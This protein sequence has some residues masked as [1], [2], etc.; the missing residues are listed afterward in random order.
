MIVLFTI[1][2]FFLVGCKSDREI[3]IDE[4]LKIAREEQGHLFDIDYSKEYDAIRYIPKEEGVVTLVVDTYDG[5]APYK[6]WGS[7]TPNFIYL[8]ELLSEL[9]DKDLGIIIV[10]PD[11]IDEYLLLIRDGKVLYNFIN[12]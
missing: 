5:I 4:G 10:H 2:S 12:N 8:S 6:Y 3:A 7:F 9:V 1:L 11:N